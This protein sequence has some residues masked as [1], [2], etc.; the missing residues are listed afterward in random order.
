ML[1]AQARVEGDMLCRRLDDMGYNRL[2]F[3]MRYEMPIMRLPACH[4]TR[5]G[6]LP[7]SF[8]EYVSILDWSPQPA[9][10]FVG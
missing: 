10:L 6:F 2:K 1:Y 8:R 5:H 9:Y 7:P 3:Y 4:S